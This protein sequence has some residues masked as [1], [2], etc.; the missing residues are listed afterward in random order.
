MNE[1]M[2]N[3]D[4]L[5]MA[6]DWKLV[7]GYSAGLTTDATPAAH[8][9]PVGSL[10][11]FNVRFDLVGPGA[12]GTRYKGH[13]TEGGDLH[14]ASLEEPG[15]L[16]A[17]TFYANRGVYVVQIIEHVEQYFAVLSGHHHRYPV[18]DPARVEIVGGWADIGGYVANFTLVKISNPM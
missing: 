2:M 15:A 16:V 9:L 11:T 13:Y 5:D 7:Y 8:L 14:P 17:E 12:H 18:D 3:N 4:T 1:I 10:R 6:G